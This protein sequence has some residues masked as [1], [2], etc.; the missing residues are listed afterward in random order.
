MISWRC[1]KKSQVKRT[2]N[3]LGPF[4]LSVA[5]GCVVVVEAWVVVVSGGIVTVVGQGVVVVVEVMGGVVCTG[6]VG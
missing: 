6:F 5:A 2:K 3:S 1:K 4:E